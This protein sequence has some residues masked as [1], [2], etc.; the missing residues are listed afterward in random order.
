VAL[1]LPPAALLG[2]PRL[3]AVRAPFA[4]W[5]EL[6][7]RVRAALPVDGNGPP[8]VVADN[9]VPAAQLD[10]ALRGSAAVLTLDHPRNAAHGR[11]P[12]F[13]RW[14]RDE[15]GLRAHA[16]RRVLL[17]LQPDRLPRAE[18]PAWRAHVEALF[19][20]L[21]PL[22]TL[23][24]PAARTEFELLSARVLPGALPADGPL[25]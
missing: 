21:R 10:H 13:S 8:L 12:Q 1:L 23:P 17:V 24:V 3:P 15:S 5:D 4:G 9:Y 18:R 2:W 11:A 16:G 14:G 22:E 6:A 20:E 7:A 19:D 25:R